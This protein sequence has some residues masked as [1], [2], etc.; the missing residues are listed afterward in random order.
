MFIVIH[1]NIYNYFILFVTMSNC[2]TKIDFYSIFF[3]FFG[4]FSNFCYFKNKTTRD[5]YL[6]MNQFTPF[7]YHF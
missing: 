3:Q 4:Y 5:N 1:I 2:Q 6:T 7:L